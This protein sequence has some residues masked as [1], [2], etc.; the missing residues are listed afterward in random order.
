MLNVF[1]SYAHE[2][3]PWRRELEKHLSILKRQGLITGWYDGEISAGAEWEGEIHAHLEAAQLIL[4]LVSPDFLASDYCYSIEMTRA[5]VRHEAGE[6]RV[7]PIILRPCDWNNT[8]LRNLQALPQDAKPVTRWSNRDQAFLNITEG[9]RRVVHDL[10][11]PVAASKASAQ[12]SAIDNRGFFAQQQTRTRCDWYAHISMPPNYVERAAV[13]ADMRDRLLTDSR[14][15]VLTSKVHSHK[16]GALHGMG[17]IGKSVAARALCDDPRVQAAFPDG[18]LW[19]TLGQIPD[20][21]SELRKWVQAL[22]GAITEHVPTVDGLKAALANLLKDRACLLILDDVWQHADAEAFSVGGP[23]CRLLLTTRDAEIAHELGAQVQPVPVMTEEEA[24]TLLDEWADGQ[25]NEVES[26]QKRQIVK[27]VGYLPLAVKL[28]G[29]Q[30]RRKPPHEWLSTFDVRKLKA[31][32]PEGM[33]G[34]L[35]LTFRLSLDALAPNVRHLYIALAIFKEDEDIPQV[36][37]ERLWHG[38]ADV[39]GDATSDVLDD[40]AARALLEINPSSR[41]VRLHDLLCGLI[42]AELGNRGIQAHQALLTAYRSRCQGTGWHTA[43]DDGYLYDHLAY[44]L[45]A[46]GALDEL[47]GLFAN[48]HWLHKRVPQ[49]DY[50]YDG[51]LSDL[52]LTWKC[53]H[54]E[55]RRQIEAAQELT[56]FTDCIRY[57][58]IRTSINGIAGNYVPEF[59]ARAVETGLWTA[60]RALSVVAK[61]PDEAKRAEMCIALLKVAGLSGEQQREVQRLGWKAAL[62]VPYEWERARV[63][64]ALAPQLPGERRNEVLERALEAA[65]AMPYEWGRAEVLAALAPQL[66]GPMLERALEAALAVPHEGQRAEVLAALAPQLPGERRNEVLERALAAALAVPHEGLRV[67]ALIPFLSIIEDQG[68]L[69]HSIRQVM[70]DYSWSMQYASREEVL[71]RYFVKKVLAPSIF[72]PQTLGIIASHI[73]EIC[74]QWGWL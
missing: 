70:L 56:A 32:R 24:I 64:A 16:P 74:E 1:Y 60:D 50:T 38:L 37:I 67:E 46:A 9:I 28:A 3:E 44:H 25:L 72:S 13:L 63:L 18:I 21:V 5:I 27:R 6:V 33:H 14:T 43:G 58:L 8:R 11:P 40:F 48:Q 42:D 54:S 62:A 7:I 68:L 53:A 69:L 12:S 19:A 30:L 35:A 17:G 73:T 55:A 61:I 15:I 71:N 31:L 34:D 41:K 66:T 10:G 36:G 51:Y 39:D 57:L 65:L 4:L 23:H 52:M 20:L 26:E 47:K 29:A 2:D 45:H 59:I 49:R 22:G